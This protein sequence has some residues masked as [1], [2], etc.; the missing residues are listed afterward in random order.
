MATRNSDVGEENE[1]LEPR[2]AAGIAALP[3]E[4]APPRDLW[5]GIAGRLPAGNPPVEEPAPGGA[6]LAAP[7]PFRPRHGF[8]RQAAAALVSAAAGAL[9]T[10][11]SLGGAAL[12]GGKLGEA[13]AALSA[14]PAA[15]AEVMP[16]AFPREERE[17]AVPGA[18]GYRLVEADYLR[19]KEAL[20]ISV[21]ARRS[22]FSPATLQA[23]E[24]NFAIIDQAIFD[25][26][27]ALDE[28]PGNRRL[29]EELYRNHRRSLD[30]LRRL[31]DT[32]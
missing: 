10:Y 27:R 1:R 25:L 9:I 21:Y 15:A 24:K 14:R 11:V 20:W 5:P 30:L 29:E 8:W 22:Q 3:R 23:V 31:A 16:A 28:D 19:A 13:G 7:I 32:T 17:E 4:L 26:R 12:G 6:P 2:L 18:A